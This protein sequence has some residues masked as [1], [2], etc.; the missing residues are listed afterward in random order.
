MEDY[1]WAKLTLVST[2]TPAPAAA[3]GGAGSSMFSAGGQQLTGEWDAEQAALSCP[4]CVG[5]LGMSSR[6]R[7]CTSAG[8]R[9]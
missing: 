7:F 2:A 6:R 4:V 1:L 9:S 3:A 8:Y 5:G